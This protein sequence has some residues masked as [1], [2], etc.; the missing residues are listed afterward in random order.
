[1]VRASDGEAVKDWT[2][3][4]VG[5]CRKGTCT[6][7]VKGMRKLERREVCCEMISQMGNRKGRKMGG[8]ISN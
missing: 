6:E 3:Y 7:E 2:R 1:M 4:A 8:K 5:Q